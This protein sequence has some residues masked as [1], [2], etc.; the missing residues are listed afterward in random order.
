[1]QSPVL[2]AIKMSFDA[3]FYYVADLDRA[4]AFYRDVLGFRLVSRDFVARFDIDGV[5]F[6]LV[7]APHDRTV[8]GAGNGRLCLQVANIQETVKQLRERGVDTS[9]VKEVAGGFLSFFRDP[10]GNELCLWQYAPTRSPE[11][12]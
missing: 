2:P 9:E 7:P 10:D 5:L 11:K 12:N 4:V 3:V 8:S 6:E 1:M